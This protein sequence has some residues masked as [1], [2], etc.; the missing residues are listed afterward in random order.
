MAS[1]FEPESQAWGY[2][3]HGFDASLQFGHATH[4]TDEI[5]A[6]ELSSAFSALPLPMLPQIVSD[7]TPLFPP[8]VAQGLSQAGPQVGLQAGPQ[9]QQPTKQPPLT[10]A[11][12]QQRFLQQLN[13]RPDQYPDYGIMMDPTLV[14]SREALA[15]LPDM[16]ESD[17]DKKEEK[18]GKRATNR[19]KK[20]AEWLKRLSESIDAFKKYAM[21]WMENTLDFPY[22]NPT[23]LHT[24]LPPGTNIQ[25]EAI[26]QD[27]SPILPHTFFRS[28][29]SEGY[30]V[31]GEH[32]WNMLK[33]LA[34]PSGELKTRMVNNRRK[35]M[36]TSISAEQLPLSNYELQKDLPSQKMPPVA[37]V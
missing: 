9:Q 36:E 5:P 20:R 6:L 10:I 22:V 27:K 21:Q 17:I 13:K 11:E 26:R 15:N 1:K 16:T 25:P 4:H 30:R 29:Q 37:Y 31:L 33:I 34:T 32:W 35:H 8:Q 2:G 3:L 7:G 24:H 23:L 14:R 12:H 19:Q 18:N 28:Y